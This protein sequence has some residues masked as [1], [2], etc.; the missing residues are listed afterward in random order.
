[1]WIDLY[2]WYYGVYSGKIV[3][4]KG[5]VVGNVKIYRSFF[6]DFERFVL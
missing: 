6:S 3:K 4:K 1:M 5:L 2:R